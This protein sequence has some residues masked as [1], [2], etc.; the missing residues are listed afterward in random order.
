MGKFVFFISSFLF[1]TGALAAD[2][3]APIVH[4]DQ[5][6]ESVPVEQLQGPGIEVH[7]VAEQKK[8]NSWSL[9]IVKEREDAFAIA[10]LDEELK[11]LDQYDRD[12]LYLRAKNS[13]YD[14]L[15]AQYAHLPK[16]KLKV[17]ASLLKEQSQPKE[18]IKSKKGQ[19]W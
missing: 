7:T 8:N 16:E 11:D 10:K 3:N 17:L 9:P 18:K 19:K 2:Q 6:D 5:M 13:N 4:V 1:A 12:M 14:A 15:V